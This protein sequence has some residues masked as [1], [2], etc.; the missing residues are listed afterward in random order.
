MAKK[1]AETTQE[2]QASEFRNVKLPTFWKEEPRLWFTMLEREFAAYNIKADAVK[3]SVVVRNLDQATMKIILDVIEA[4]PEKSTYEDIKQAL[5][6][7][8]AKSEEA[9]LRKLISGIELG[10]RKPLELLREMKQLAGKSVTESATRTMWIQRLPTRTQ[11]ILA[12]LEETPM[13]K[14][15]KIANKSRE[16][17]EPPQMAAI[18]DATQPRKEATPSAQNGDLAAITK[19]LA[20]IETQ[21]ARRHRSPQRYEHARRWYRQRSNSKSQERKNG[22]CYYHNRFKGN[23]NRCRPPCTWTAPDKRTPEN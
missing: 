16:W 5:I 8:M 1:V 19:R 3:S 14:I 6:E 13:E 10:N 23:S 17:S 21:L 7:R 2:I 22:F 9:N 12:L 18:S 20:R 11:E 15:A 4:P